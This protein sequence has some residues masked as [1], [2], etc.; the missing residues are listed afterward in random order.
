MKTTM[1]STFDKNLFTFLKQLKKNNNREWFQKNKHRY[2][3]HVKDPLLDFICEVRAPLLKICDNL[4][5]DPKSNGGSLLRIYRDTRFSKEK[6]PYKTNAGLQFPFRPVN[7]GIHAPGFYLHLE[8]DASFAAAGSWHPDPIA[9]HQIRTAIV[10]HPKKWEKVL[11]KK[12]PLE[13]TSLIRPPRGFN[14]EHPFIEDLKRKDFI[15]SISFTDAQVCSKNFLKTYIKACQEM[16]PLMHFLI[17]AI[18]APK[19][20]I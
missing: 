4:K 5:V 16:A 11:K 18:S 7:Q 9:L 3:D 12:I 20:L 10:K 14:A 17:E 13:G 8:P 19:S 15:T 1:T 2:E 6:I